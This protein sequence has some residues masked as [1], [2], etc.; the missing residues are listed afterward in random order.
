MF[1]H[2]LHATEYSST[3]C[4]HRMCR[5]ITSWCCCK[6]LILIL[7]NTHAKSSGAQC[8]QLRH[9]VTRRSDVKAHCSLA[10]EGSRY[11]GQCF[12]FNVLGLLR[13]TCVTV[14][15]PEHSA[16]SGKSLRIDAMYC[17]RIE[18]QSK[19]TLS[20][21]NDHFADHTRVLSTG[22]GRQPS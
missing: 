6:Q 14:T 17:G 3:V 18:V 19:Q 2:R 5:G 8:R 21:P 7:N 16:G 22:A 11:L 15:V 10:M 13:Q 9:G 1:L 20:P 12:L 4:V